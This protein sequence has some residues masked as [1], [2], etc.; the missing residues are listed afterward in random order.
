L[1]S[2]ADVTYNT[3]SFPHLLKTLCALLKATSHIVAGKQPV[4][5][6]AYKQRDVAEK[7]LWALLDDEG[8]IMEPVST[9]RGA[10][11]EGPVEIWI[12]RASGAHV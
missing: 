11:E 6:L 8:I 9:V 1:F 7:G 10:E 4:V 2:A 5:L 3:A 12:G